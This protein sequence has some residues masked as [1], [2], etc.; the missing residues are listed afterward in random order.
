MRSLFRNGYSGVAYYAGWLSTALSTTATKWVSTCT[1]TNT[2]SGYYTLNV[3]GA[4]VSG[5]VQGMLPPDA[6][7]IN[8]NVYVDQEWSAFGVAEL[9]TWDR[10]L[11]D[12][13]LREVQGY[14]T[15]KFGLTVE[16][17]PAPPVPAAP[18]PPVASMAQSLS[19]GLVTWYSM[20]GYKQAPQVAGQPLSQEAGTWTSQLNTNA[21]ALTLTDRDTDVAGTFGNSV[22]ITYV[23][24]SSATK[25]I[26][27]EVYTALTQMS[28]CTVTR[29]T[30]NLATFRAR[31]FQPYRSTTNWLHG[32]WNGYSGVAYYD[33]WLT[34]SLSTT[35]E[36]A[37]A[38]HLRRRS[39][40]DARASPDATRSSPAQ[41]PSGSAPAQRTTPSPART[42]ST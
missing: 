11:T 24:G 15:T 32:H 8:G 16:T 10:A 14:L 20:D 42:R 9:I 12:T 28:I 23:S 30:S 17:P 19:N 39:R 6:L 21:A 40:R 34:T 25:I 31:V 41:P 5:W 38:W 37:A 3:D 4:S 35:G 2:G 7:T 29:Y 13:E 36:C 1:S 18:R 22:P 27:P 26:F 33:G